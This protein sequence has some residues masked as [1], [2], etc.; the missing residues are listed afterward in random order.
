[1]KNEIKVLKLI[2]AEEVIT[3]MTEGENGVLLLET[4]M[5]V[6]WRTS[7]AGRTDI[8]LIPWSFGGKIDK[9]TLESK[10]VLVILEVTSEMEKNYLSSISGITL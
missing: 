8:N 10:H 6:H 3:R 1:M 4:P 7:P 5:T 2:T 9:V